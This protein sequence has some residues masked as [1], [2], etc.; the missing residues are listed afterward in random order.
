[1]ILWPQHGCEPGLGGGCTK[2]FSLTWT[3][4]PLSLWR[5]WMWWI[6]CGGHR[7]LWGMMKYHRKLPGGCFLW[8]SSSSLRTCSF[9]HEQEDSQRSREEMCRVMMCV[10]VSA[11]QICSVI[12]LS[13]EVSRE[14]SVG[15]KVPGG[16]VKSRTPLSSCPSSCGPTW[17]TFNSTQLN[18]TQHVLLFYF[19]G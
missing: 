15:Y 11:P 16:N 5:G 18:T 2:L 6:N 8:T 3:N 10:E 17:G 7:F 12:T 4:Q 1:M 14:R 13:T 9:P 19:W